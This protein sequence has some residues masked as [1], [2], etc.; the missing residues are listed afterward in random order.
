MYANKIF[1]I[2][3]IICLLLGISA[4]IINFLPPQIKDYYLNYNPNI[5]YSDHQKFRVPSHNNT[6]CQNNVR[7]TLEYFDRYA[8]DN[9]ILYTAIA[10]TLIGAYTRKGMIPW[11]DDADI[12]IRGSDWN[13]FFKLWEN[14]NPAKN[15]GILSRWEYK[16][17]NLYGRDFILYRN[18]RT[19]NWYK[20]KLEQNDYPEIDIGGIDIG[21]IFYDENRKNYYESL[22]THK[23]APKLTRQDDKSVVPYMKFD[24][25]K[26]GIRAVIPHRGEK[27]LTDWYGEQW[28]I[29]EKPSKDVLGKIYRK[30]KGS[31]EE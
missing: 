24:N 3:L 14:G 1:T 27:Y 28:K 15:I 5:T 21:Y 22:N 6:L 25:L 23:I 13:K 31:L 29:P 10:G 4:F 8:E 16:K 20:L 2:S 17:I 19:H 7:K 30:D 11:D 12:A 9:D 26:P 18:K